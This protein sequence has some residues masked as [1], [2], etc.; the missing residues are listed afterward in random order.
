[1]LNKAKDWLYIAIAVMGFFGTAYGLGKA[2]EHR[3]S[4]IESNRR[5][6]EQN[7]KVITEMKQNATSATHRLIRVEEKLEAIKQN[8]EEIKDAIKNGH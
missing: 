1:M 6:A 8:Q 7:C 2:F 4:L 5:Q 3:D